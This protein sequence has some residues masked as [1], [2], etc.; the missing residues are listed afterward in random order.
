MIVCYTIYACNT[1]YIEHHYR[2]QKAAF[3]AP[4][5]AFQ[6]DKW[7]QNIFA[8]NHWH[9]FGVTSKDDTIL[10]VWIV[11]HFWDNQKFPFRIHTS[12]LTMRHLITDWGW[13]LASYKWHTARLTQHSH[14]ARCSQS[15][16]RQLIVWSDLIKRDRGLRDMQP[17]CW[18]LDGIN[19]GYID[20]NNKGNATL[21]S[22][23][24]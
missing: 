2:Q 23:F 19:E 9:Q 4:I 22:C 3:T 17:A 10:R 14:V 15:T 6:N 21:D 13:F 18:N 24:F 7:Y 12:N 1:L 5:M 11:H 20:S 16:R 8:T